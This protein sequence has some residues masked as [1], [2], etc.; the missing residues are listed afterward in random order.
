M[1][2][3]CGNSGKGAKYVTLHAVRGRLKVYY[4]E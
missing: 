3:V 2:D 1:A 4:A